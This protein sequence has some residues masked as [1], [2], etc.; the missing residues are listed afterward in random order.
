MAV[1]VSHAHQCGEQHL[2]GVVGSVEMCGYQ[3]ARTLVLVPEPAYI[4][5]AVPPTI[6][7]VNALH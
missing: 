2:Q 1:A 3:E 7:N 6:P 5:G 4:S